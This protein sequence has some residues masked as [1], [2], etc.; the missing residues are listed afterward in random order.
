MEII[1]NIQNYSVIGI[2]GIL[3]KILISIKYPI[4]TLPGAL[5][6]SL[7]LILISILNNLNII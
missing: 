3:F 7:N 2:F 5:G 4:L 6:K 1:Q